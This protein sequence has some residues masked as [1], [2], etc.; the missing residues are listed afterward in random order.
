MT[1]DELMKLRAKATPG[2][3]R[4]DPV[5]ETVVDSNGVRIASLDSGVPLRD[6]ME[7]NGRFIAAACS[8]VLGLSEWALHDA[9]PSIDRG[10]S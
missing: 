7:A 8:F 2:E 9:F 1:I 5:H 4:W 6:E 3:W 10:K